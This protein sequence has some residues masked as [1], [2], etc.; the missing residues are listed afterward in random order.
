MTPGYARILGTI[1]YE[2]M[3]KML[4]ESIVGQPHRSLRH[5]RKGHKYVS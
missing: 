1:G 3:D 5:L 4:Y 2:N